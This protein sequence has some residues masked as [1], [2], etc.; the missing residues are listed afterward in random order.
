MN[1]S[2][3]T[4]AEPLR[5]AR[6][7][8]NRAA[9]FWIPLVAICFC[10]SGATLLGFWLGNSKQADTD[11]LLPLFASS[12]SATETMAV[13]TGP[14]SPEA[15]GI[16]FLDFITGD[17]QCL[18]YYPRQRAFGAR[19][20]TNVLQHLGGGGKNPRYTMVAGSTITPFTTGGAQPSNC[21][22]YIADATSGMFAAY[23]VPWDRNAER[24]GQMQSGPLI[25]AG[26]GPIRNFQLKDP[27]QN[28]PA[29][30]VDPNQKP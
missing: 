26:G 2:D 9:R 6:S 1:D 25:Y 27:A 7:D 21:L 3:Q 17:L 19:Y 23:T 13:A 20:L 4:N 12:A 10:M 16:F 28:Q 22:I 8:Y 14:I 18:V 30:V 29:A 24:S 15:D 11:T 5:L